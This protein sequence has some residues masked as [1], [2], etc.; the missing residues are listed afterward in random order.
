MFNLGDWTKRLGKQQSFTVP[1][2]ENGKALKLGAWGLT[3]ET[4]L[5]LSRVIHPIGR[6][7]IGEV[8]RYISRIYDLILIRKGNFHLDLC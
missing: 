8:L 1:I 4:C 6:C 3:S 5:Y 2:L 7:L